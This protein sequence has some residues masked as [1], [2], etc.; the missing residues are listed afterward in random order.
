[1][2]K[3]TNKVSRKNYNCAVDTLNNLKKLYPKGFGDCMSEDENDV[4]ETCLR[5]INSYKDQIEQK[6]RDAAEFLDANPDLPDLPMTW[7]PMFVDFARYYRSVPYGSRQKLKAE[8]YDIKSE[9]GR[10]YTLPKYIMIMDYYD[11]LTAKVA[12]FYG[13]VAN[14]TDPAEVAKKIEQIKEKC[15]DT[16]AIR[17]YLEVVYD[18]CPGYK[19]GM[20]YQVTLNEVIEESKEDSPKP[21]QLTLADVFPDF[22]HPDKKK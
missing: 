11:N 6:A 10:K 14:I 4:L 16:W 5:I 8:K 18:Y 2:S 20:P 19:K 3:K 1:M 21:K 7:S 22:F 17:Q 12:L 9:G 13:D 15:D